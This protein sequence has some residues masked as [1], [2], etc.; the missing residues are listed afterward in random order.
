MRDKL[1]PFVLSVDVELDRG[2]GDPAMWN[3][4]GVKKDQRNLRELLRSAEQVA[5]LHLTLTSPRGHFFPH[6]LLNLVNSVVA[7]A[8]VEDIRRQVGVPEP[9]PHL[10]EF[11]EQRLM[12]VVAT[13]GEKQYRRTTS[14]QKAVNAVHE[15]E[16]RVGADKARQIFRIPLGQ[17]HSTGEKESYDRQDH[18]ALQGA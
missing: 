13:R 5:G 7:V 10:Q 16:E 17:L 12:E 8:D 18:L 15:L 14:G 9:E 4:G 2:S 6:Q 3:R 1:R 11:L